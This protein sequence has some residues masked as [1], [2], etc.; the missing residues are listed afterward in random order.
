M[1]IFIEKLADFS[2]SIS[3]SIN[4][5]ILDNPIKSEHL[6]KLRKDLDDCDSLEDYNSMQK[7]IENRRRNNIII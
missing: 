6:Q 2:R 7:I 3:K 5:I 4:F 1:E